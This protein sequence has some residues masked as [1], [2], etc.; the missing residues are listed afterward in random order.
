VARDEAA[1][2]DFVTRL[3]IA[4]LSR[5]DAADLLA[6][7]RRDELDSL[8]REGAAIKE[9]MAA[10]RRLHLAGL[11]TE[12]EFASGRRKRQAD[13]AAIEQR[14]AEAGQAGVVAR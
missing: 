4:R 10:D 8:H 5:D 6:E 14:I 11:L 1:L 9:L 3:V 2:D 13:L 12:M 7:D